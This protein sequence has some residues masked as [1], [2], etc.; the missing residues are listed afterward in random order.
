M[1]EHLK[2]L[3]KCLLVALG[4]SIIGIWIW[5]SYINSLQ[6]EQQKEVTEIIKTTIEQEAQKGI[7]LPELVFINADSTRKQELTDSLLSQIS[8]ILTEK[9]LHDRELSVNDISLKPFFVLPNKP[10]SSG[11]YILTEGQLKGLSSHINFLTKQVEKEVDRTKEEVGRDIDRLN[12]WV[13]I[14]IGVIGFLGI[15]I[16]IVLNIDVSKRASEAKEEAGKAIRESEK[17]KSNSEMA[18]KEANE[19]LGKINGAQSQINKIDGLEEKAENASRKSDNAIEKAEKALSDTVEVKGNLSVILAIN[20]L[21]EFTPQTLIQLNKANVVHYFTNVLRAILKELKANE[22]FFNSEYMKNWLGQVAI[23]SQNISLYKFINPEQT[24]LLN[25]Y[26]ELITNAL[27]NYSR[28]QFDKIV[29]G[30]EELIINL[31]TND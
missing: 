5:Q 8:T 11:N 20:R 30:L 7:L 10:D 14:W 16:P 17:A 4:L 1:T 9:Y 24:R 28:E 12:T 29:E 13:S 22:E 25:D 26:A 19:A 15:F 3:G 23:N 2:I 27:D 18:S 21:K 6:S 31:N